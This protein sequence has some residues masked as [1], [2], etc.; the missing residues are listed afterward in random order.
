[1]TDIDTIRAKFPNC[2]S[3]ESL[4]QTGKATN[5]DGKPINATGLSSINNLLAL[6]HLVRTEK[7]SRTL[8]IGLAYGGSALAIIST[9]ESIDSSGNFFHTAIDPGQD[10]FGR[11]G[12]NMV[13]L[14]GFSRSFR[15]IEQSSDLA[16]PTLA[17]KNEQFELI[18]IDIQL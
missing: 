8:E 18:Y 4:Y 3:L 17:I 5:I 6:E 12:I 9:L 2:S 10:N 13:D 7:P 11:A 14:S 15:C 16:L 1:M